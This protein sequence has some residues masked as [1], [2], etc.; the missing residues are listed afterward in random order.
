MP[1]ARNITI[2]DMAK[3]LGGCKAIIYDILM[4]GKGVKEHDNR[5]KAIMSR[6]REKNLKLSRKK[7]EFRKSHATNEGRVFT[8]ERIQPDA[9]KICAVE[10]L[11]EHQTVFGFVNDTNPIG[12]YHSDF[13]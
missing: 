12:V 2:S 11:P 5:R 4:W 3:D 9:E 10:E 8:P 13:S 1:F 7:C 6:I